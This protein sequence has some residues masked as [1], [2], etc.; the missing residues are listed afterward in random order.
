MSEATQDRLAEQ[1]RRSLGREPT[2]AELDAAARAWADDEMLYREAL[3]LGLDRGDPIV[4][5]RLVQKM[6]FLLE[7]A[8]ELPEPTDAELE[9]WIAEHADAFEQA[10]RVG[11][12]HVFVASSSRVVPEAELRALEDALEAGADPST[13]GDAF[14]LGQVL[15]P[16]TRADLN[17]QFGEKFGDAVFGL[18]AI[19]DDSADG[20]GWQRLRSLYG[21][22]LVHVDARTP[23]RLATV[24]EVRSQARQGLLQDAREAAETAALLELRERYSVE[25]EGAR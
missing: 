1:R 16:K 22:H 7:D 6:R 4:R 21:W 17:R 8:G 11:F 12:T 13:L 2:A 25:I 19:A 20:P 10:P 18:D 14:V 3:A 5:R 23:G 24:D 15:P 9:A